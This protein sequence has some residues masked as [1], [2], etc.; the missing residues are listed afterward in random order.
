MLYAALSVLS[1]YSIRDA[2]ESCS[3]P[4]RRAEFS[5]SRMKVPKLA[6]ARWGDVKPLR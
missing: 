2:G 6:T 3:Y 1:F 5:C 4:V